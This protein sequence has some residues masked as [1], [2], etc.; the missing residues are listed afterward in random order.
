[1]KLSSQNI[2]VH[3]LKLKFYVIFVVQNL[4]WLFQILKK[5]GGGV[6]KISSSW[7]LEKQSQQCYFGYMMTNLAQS[8]LFATHSCFN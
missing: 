5:R 7:S 4:L 6:K 8:R 2:F 1:M 3:T